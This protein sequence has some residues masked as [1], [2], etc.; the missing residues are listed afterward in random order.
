MALQFEV[1]VNVFN[2]TDGQPLWGCSH[3]EV[4]P[5]TEDAEQ[6]VL[7]L[8]VKVLERIDEARTLIAEQVA[9]DAPLVG[10]EQ[11]QDERRQERGRHGGGRP[12]G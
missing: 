9:V 12:R 10:R 6:N 3:T 11:T 4:F 8:G 2:T 7:N 1:T 5:G